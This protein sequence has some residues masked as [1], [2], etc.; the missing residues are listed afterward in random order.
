[1][2]RIARIIF[3]FLGEIILILYSIFICIILS[4]DLQIR[5]LTAQQTLICTDYLQI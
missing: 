4:L 5:S 2:I 1:M 3:T